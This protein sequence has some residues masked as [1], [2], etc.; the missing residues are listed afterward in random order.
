ML[1]NSWGFLIFLP[2]VLGLYFALQRHLKLQNTMLL[3]ASYIFYGWWDWR[4]LSLILISSILDFLCGR[5]IFRSTTQ[6][7]KKIFLAFS[8]LGNLGLLGFF[9]YFN[10]FVDSAA[11][12]LAG[13]GLEAHLPVLKIILPVGISFYTFQT[14][15]YTIDIYRGTFK[16]TNN[17]LNFMLYVSY[18]PQLVAGPIER[19]SHL[20]PEL[21]KPRI[22]TRQQIVEGITLIL[23]GFFRKVVIADNLAPMVER[24]FS[25]PA[26]ASSGL[27]LGGLYA[28][29]LQIYGDFAGYSDI[30]RGVSKIMGI[31]LMVNFQQPYFSTSITEFWRRWHISL[32]SW[33]RDYL[34]ID[35]LGGN[36]KGKFRTYFNLFLTMFLGGLWHGAAWTFVAWG[37]LN[38]VYLAVEKMTLFARKKFEFPALKVSFG[39][40]VVR[41]LRIVFVFHLVCLTWIFFRAPNFTVASQYLTSIFTNGGWLEL[42][43]PALFISWLAI[44]A[45]DIPIY[46]SRDHTV[47]LKLPRLAQ[48]LVFAAIILII[49]TY[50]ANGKTPFIYF[51]F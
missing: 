15:S 9:K 22:I 16:P 4:F 24:A 41:I 33:L 31:E 40:W 49:I 38:G 29:A 26:T 35:L 30:A 37:V 23:I 28:F 46:L 1:F 11:G 36:K 47:V 43:S 21:E 39:L 8:V 13:F 14:M 51:Q 20:L 3:V 7:R 48:V 6:K 18:F 45:V 25:N 12:L 32:S 42:F 19:A 44:L 50:S 27:L 10:F 34:Y 5:E 17:F 2:I